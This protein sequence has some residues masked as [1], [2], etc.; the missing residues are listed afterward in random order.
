[1]PKIDLYDFVR[2][3]EHTGIPRRKYKLSLSDELRH[4]NNNKNNNIL[5]ETA[6]LNHTLLRYSFVIVAV[7]VGTHVL[8]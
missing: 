3:M 6:H 1:M 8:F 7:S 5:T 4:D 2:S